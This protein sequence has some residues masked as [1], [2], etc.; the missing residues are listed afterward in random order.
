MNTAS[1][2]PRAR[3]RQS[4]RTSL[5]RKRPASLDMRAVAPCGRTASRIA[6][7][8]PWCAAVDSSVRGA[9]RVTDADETRAPLLSAMRYLR[10]LNATRSMQMLARDAASPKQITA[11]GLNRAIAMRSACLAEPGATPPTT[12]STA[13]RRA[14][15]AAIGRRACCATTRLTISSLGFDALFPKGSKPEM[16]I[17]TR[18]QP[19]RDAR[20]PVATPGTEKGG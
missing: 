5:Q 7:S 6:R 4:K 12:G 13:A 18:I 9:P 19:S 1:Y 17:C 2:L 10:S 15:P 16:R 11:W 3:C 20:R 8:M 14:R